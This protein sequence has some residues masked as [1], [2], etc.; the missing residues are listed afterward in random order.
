[1]CPRPGFGQRSQ[2]LCRGW[3]LRPRL[4]VGAGSRAQG[5][6]G[7]GLPGDRAHRGQGT[8]FPGDGAHREGDTPGS[9]HTGD[10]AHRCPGPLAMGPRSSR[11]ASP[12][13]GP[14]SSPGASPR[15]RQEP[16]A[17]LASP[18]SVPARAGT[19]LQPCP[20]PGSQ[21]ASLPPAPQRDPGQRAITVPL[22]TRPCHPAVPGCRPRVPLPR[23]RAPARTHRPQAGAQPPPLGPSPGER[24]LPP[25]PQ[26][27]TARLRHAGP[28]P[29]PLAQSERAGGWA[30]R[31]Y[32]RHGG[33]GSESCAGPGPE[34]ETGDS[35]VC[36]AGFPSES[37]AP[38]A[39]NSPQV[40]Q[41]SEQRYDLGPPRHQCPTRAHPRTSAEKELKNN[42][43]PSGCFYCWMDNFAT[44]HFPLWGPV[45]SAAPVPVP[46]A[47]GVQG[48]GVTPH[49]SRSTRPDSNG[50]GLHGG[51]QPGP[52]YS[53][54]LCEM[55][56]T[57]LC[58][59]APSSATAGSL[60]PAPAAWK[61][62]WGKIFQSIHI[63]SIIQALSP[64]STKAARL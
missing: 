60:C 56:R 28:A 39:G 37:R 55:N 53:L 32:R 7:T 17:F 42:K 22:C 27:I 36:R 15:A 62:V 18:S 14:Q 58:N 51:T 20:S 26:P 45:E 24:A 21:P 38:R 19:A 8:G 54:S 23:P 46:K 44:V 5:T 12:T 31:R 47:P 57:V 34:G 25:H 61:T 33:L 64:M 29:G 13:A 3:T 6:T 43:Q 30:G 35:I 2:G 1:M 49:C 41:P 16:S 11:R 10:R 9:G 48:A 52:G 40:L 59:T 4:W 63:F 50:P